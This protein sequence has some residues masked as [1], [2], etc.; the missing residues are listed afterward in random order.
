MNN[1]KWGIDIINTPDRDYL[2][3]LF[4]NDAKEKRIWRKYASTRRTFI[5]SINGRIVGT[6]SCIFKDFEK[7]KLPVE[8]S[9]IVTF[10]DSLNDIISFKLGP[11]LEQWVKI[12]H[13]SSV[14]ICG[15]KIDDGLS[16]YDKRRVL[17]MLFLQCEFACSS[18]ECE[19]VFLTCEEIFMQLYASK[20]RFKY[21][22][23]VAYGEKKYNLMY[24]RLNH[25]NFSNYAI[26]TVNM[27]EE[28]I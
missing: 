22:G 14:E 21:G 19:Y 24:A 2:N 26:N 20:Q 25:T 28:A 6:I 13:T 7:N 5:I 16:L 1:G 11:N 10:D 23:I 18:H 15:L 9:K 4:G 12:V 3:F 8:Y 27:N 17:A